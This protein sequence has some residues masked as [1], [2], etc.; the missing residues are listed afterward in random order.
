MK[1]CDRKL[2][3]E[4]ANSLSQRLAFAYYTFEFFRRSKYGNVLG[5]G[6]P[7]LLSRFGLLPWIFW[8]L[9]VTR[10]SSKY[11]FLYDKSPAGVIALL[12]KSDALYLS[13]VA[14]SPSSRGRGIGS[15]ILS[16]A[17]KAANKTGLKRLELTV[18]KV[19]TPAQRL[20]VRFGFAFKEES[21]YS[22]ILKKEITARW[23]D[24]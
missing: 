9:I 14:T 10:R 1:E 15:C 18:M 23:A 4:R 21:K 20:Y 8:S 2:R 11:V 17:E 3:V 6:N 16:F 22:F 12:P 7:S 13:S 24:S 19:N 5:L